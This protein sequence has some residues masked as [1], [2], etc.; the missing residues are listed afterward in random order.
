[1]NLKAE[2]KVNG[3]RLIRY[4][5]LPGNEIA[6]SEYRIVL[7]RPYTLFKSTYVMEDERTGDVYQ[8]GTVLR[9]NGS[10]SAVAWHTT[11]TLDGFDGNSQPRYI[12]KDDCGCEWSADGL[13][14]VRSCHNC[15]WQR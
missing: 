9:E 12:L 13:T 10:G 2:L 7:C 5:E 15:Y 11:K 4:T 6:E 8:A 14:L 3:D 1:M